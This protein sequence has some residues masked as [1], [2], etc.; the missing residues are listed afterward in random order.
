MTTENDNG[1]GWYV[2][3]VEDVEYGQKITPNKGKKF[4]SM[5]KT[6]TETHSLDNLECIVIK[7]ETEEKEKSRGYHNLKKY[8]VITAAAVCFAFLV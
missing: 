5:L 3:I 8:C 4:V 6:I 2:E 1:W 7:P